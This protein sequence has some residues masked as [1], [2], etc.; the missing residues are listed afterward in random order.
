M[1]FLALDGKVSAR[2]AA[3]GELEADHEESV[4]RMS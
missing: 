2:V 4:R 1:W 3:I